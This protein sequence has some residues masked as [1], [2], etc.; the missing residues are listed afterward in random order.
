MSNTSVRTILT[1]VFV[2]CGAFVLL[3]T[4]AVAAQGFDHYK[5]QVVDYGAPKDFPANPHHDVLTCFYYRG[6]MVKQFSNEWNK[7]ALF[8]SFLRFDHA[9]P[10]CV[11]EHSPEEQ[12][13]DRTEWSGYFGAGVKGALV[14]FDASDGENGGMP[15]AVYDSKTK[16]KIFEDNAYSSW[17]WNPKLRPRPS[18]FNDLRVRTTNDGNVVLTYLRVV[19]T[20]CD[21]PNNGAECWP[22]IV[23][24]LGLKTAA[25]P[26]CIRWEENQIYGASAVAYPVET[27][28]FPTPVTKTISGPVRC[29]PVD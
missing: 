2:A 21:I 9:Q 14:F 16:K 5:K 3:L 11:K 17:M 12:V 20:E 18:P 28:L 24:K 13:L 25:T 15:F 23:Q 6:L 26:R 8:L 19:A 1:R 27:S 29:W 22:Q 7:G 4:T 10:P